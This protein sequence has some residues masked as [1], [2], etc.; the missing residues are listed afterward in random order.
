MADRPTNALL[1]I[2]LIAVASAVYSWYRPPKIVT[3]TRYVEVPKEKV[4]ARIKTVKVPGPERIVTIEKERIV[5]ALE[6]PESVGNDQDKQIIANADIPCDESV[7]GQSVVTVMDTQT[8]ESRIL[9]K[10]KP[11]P[12][13]GF[14]NRKEIGARYGLTNEGP[15]V[16]VY[17]RWDF[18][19]VGSLHL[20]VY[21]E[22]NSQAEAKAMMQ[23]GYR[24]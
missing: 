18:L 13:V 3:Q 7:N 22:V 17:G 5:K 11:L 23:V 8:G 2:A 14:E 20:G 19:R 24:W 10:P 15:E 6:L 16:D 1:I 12:L 4:V 21:G 9:A